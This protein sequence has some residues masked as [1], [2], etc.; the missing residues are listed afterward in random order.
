[1]IRRL[2]LAYALLAGA[3]AYQLGA[4]AGRA[5][6]VSRSAAPLMIG[7]FGLADGQKY[8]PTSPAHTPT[9]PLPW[10]NLEEQES[11]QIVKA[12]SNGLRQPL[13]KDM[14]DDEVCLGIV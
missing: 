2:F 6:P 7:E 12:T 9:K 8:G 10:T 13:L 4:P 11:V 5:A 14:A 3:S 1:M